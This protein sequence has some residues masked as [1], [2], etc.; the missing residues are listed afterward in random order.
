MTQRKLY[1]PLPGV[2]FCIVMEN[3]AFGRS[4]ANRPAMKLALLAATCLA[5][6]AVVT[7]IFLLGCLVGWALS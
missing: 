7:V 5:E 3:T 4:I 1:L 6:V 2:T